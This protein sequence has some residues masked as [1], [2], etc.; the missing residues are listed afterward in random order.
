MD[1]LYSRV[2]FEP[3]SDGGERIV[4]WLRA[5]D[6]GLHGWEEYANGE[7]SQEIE[8]LAEDVPSGFRLVRP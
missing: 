5:D 7:R 4:Q 2:V 3:E 6:Q 1:T 8:V